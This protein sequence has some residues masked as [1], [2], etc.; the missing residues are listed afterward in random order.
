MRA[1]RMPLVAA[2]VLAVPAFLAAVQSAAGAGEDK[3]ASPPPFDAQPF[4]EEKTALP[5]KAEW[6]SAQEV[7]LDPRAKEPS[8]SAFRVREWVKLQCKAES[9][10]AL[11]ML[12]GERDGLQMRL[13]DEGNELGPGPSR[14]EMVIPVRRGDARVIELMTFE[15]GYKGSTSVEPWRVLSEIWPAE[16]DRP[17]IVLQ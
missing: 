12:A 6:R 17:T 11:R 10:G 2:A 4:P 8:C 16:D 9:F 14:A 13:E 5:T 7:T 15:F 3:D 1:T